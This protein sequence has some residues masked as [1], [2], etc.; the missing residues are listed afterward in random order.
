[1]DERD[2]FILTI[3]PADARDFDDALSLDYVDGAVRLGV[4]IADVSHYVPWGSALDLDLSPYTHFYLFNPFDPN[5]LERFILALEE[6]L[7]HPFTLIH[8]S[9]NGDTWRYVGRPG[10]SE[11]ASGSIKNCQNDRGHKFSVYEWP[12]HYTVWHYDGAQR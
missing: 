12:Q 11:L 1:I 6:Q 10:W 7:T 9:D 2:R 4:H 3:D 5:V 8:M